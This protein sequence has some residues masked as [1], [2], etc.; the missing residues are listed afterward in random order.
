MNILSTIFGRGNTIDNLDAGEIRKEK[1]R[2]EV[3][4]QSLAKQ[5]RELGAK[6]TREFLD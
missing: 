5:L 6:K 4:E 1:V 3:E 2:L